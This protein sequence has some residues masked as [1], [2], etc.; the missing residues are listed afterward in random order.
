MSPPEDGAV[1]ELDLEQSREA[2]SVARAAVAGL[3]DDFQIEGTT[4]ARLTLLVSEIVT[5][6]VLH[7][8]AGPQTVIRLCVR[9]APQ[10]IRVEVTDAGRGFTPGKRDPTR[11]TDGYG[12]F[13]L[14]KESKR[15]GVERSGGTRV[16]F[17][18]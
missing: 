4:L 6:A 11:P 8:G 9:I 12:L 16:W 14:E 18:L 3:A 17:E 13:L 15:W 2:P 10:L 1:L 5:N 7:S